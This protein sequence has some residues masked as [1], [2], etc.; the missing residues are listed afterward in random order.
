[1]SVVLDGRLQSALQIQLGRELAAALTYKQYAF[2]FALQGWQGF[3]KWAIA[4]EKEEL[5]HAC[6][7]GTFLIGR[8]VR[9]TV[10]AMLQLPPLLLLERPLDVF[11]LALN[12][13][14]SFWGYIE[15]I[16]SLATDVDDYDT[17]AFLKVKIE[18]QHESVAQ[19]TTIVTKMRRA[20]GDSAAMQIL[21]KHILEIR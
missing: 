7:F 21:D 6:D 1:M 12:L 14:K 19:L 5:G 16:Y 20:D 11:E 13:E 18:Q 4:Q 10:P 3:E 8:N 17:C 9:A 15:E 2:D